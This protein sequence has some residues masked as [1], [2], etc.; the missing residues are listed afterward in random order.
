MQQIFPARQSLLESATGE[1]A[2]ALVLDTNVALDLL[3]FGD[4]HCR[5]IAQ[6]LRARLRR[7]CATPQ[8]LEEFERVLARAE[9]ARWAARRDGARRRWARWV[10]S[11]DTPASAADRLCCRDADD[12]V[13][14][15]LAVQLRPCCLLSR[16]DQVLR[17]RQP[18]A[19]LG[20]WIARPQEWTEWT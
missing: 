13:F 9:F 10:S 12:Q 15:D 16:D 6:I 19:A 4:V 11:V 2:A 18:A 1:T 8:M 3:V 17:L 5:A 7:W 14:I 20:V